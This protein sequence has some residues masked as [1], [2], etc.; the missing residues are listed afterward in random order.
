MSLLSLS[1]RGTLSDF[2]SNQSLSQILKRLWLVVVVVV[3]V[4]VVVVVVV[5]VLL[6]WT[7][8]G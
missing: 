4:A 5:V 8:K 3:V 2:S 6:S 1:L 7:R